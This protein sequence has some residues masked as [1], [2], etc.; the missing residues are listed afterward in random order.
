MKIIRKIH[1]KRD[2]KTIIETISDYN[3][4]LEKDSQ[5]STDTNDSIYSSNS[6]LDSLG[7]VSFIIALEQSIEDKFKVSISLADEKAMSQKSNPYA[8]INSLAEYISKL[9]DK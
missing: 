4:D 9:I 3:K 1:E 7:L 6:N 5:I 2:Y 8:T